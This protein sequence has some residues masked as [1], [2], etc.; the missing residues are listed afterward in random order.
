ML[1]NHKGLINMGAFVNVFRTVAYR[2]DV[3]G[4]DIAGF[5][6]RRSVMRPNL[7]VLAIVGIVFLSIPSMLHADPVSVTLVGDLQSEIGCIDWQ[8]NCAAS[9]LSY[10]GGDLWMETFLIPAGSWE[11]LIATNDNWLGTYGLGGVKDGPN[12]PLVLASNNWVR[13]TYNQL[14]HEITHSVVPEPSALLLLGL[15]LAGMCALRKRR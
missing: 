6:S 10:V 4:I 1:T 14:T 5:P 13:F 11:Y 7:F 15:G 8:P 3:S 12:I 9:H 2:I